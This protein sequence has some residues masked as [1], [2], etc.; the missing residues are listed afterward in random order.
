MSRVPSLRSLEQE[1]LNRTMEAHRP[2]L[3]Q[4]ARRYG[5]KDSGDIWKLAERVHSYEEEHIERPK[6]EAQAREL[7]VATRTFGFRRS[8]LSIRFD[9]YDIE[10][11]QR[12][13][14]ELGYTK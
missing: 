4:R 5:L 11:R 7:G 2:S 12:L 9:I 6:V 10:K 3:E 1:D 13:A 14:R 8:V